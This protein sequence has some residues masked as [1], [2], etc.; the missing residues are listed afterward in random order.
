MSA[1]PLRSF[2]AADLPPHAHAQALQATEQLRKSI[3][4]GVRWV[5]TENLHLTLK[6]LGDVDPE[7]IP[8]LIAAASARLQGA[9]S[10]EVELGG[11]GVFP[12]ARR[13]RVVWLGVCAGG[14]ELARLARKLDRAAGR[15]GVERERRPFRTHLTLGRLQQPGPVPLN[16]VPCPAGRPFL[17]EEIVLYESRLSSTGARY[18]PLARLPL[19]TLDTQQTNFAP[20]M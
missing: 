20:D 13:A 4:D 11:L 19:G 16:E 7:R 2:L 9:A 12:N 1:E 15:I 3:P 10:F 8:E 14:A 18:V 6:F 17:V 5:P